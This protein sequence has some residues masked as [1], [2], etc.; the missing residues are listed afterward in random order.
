M[1][2]LALA[3]S[4]QAAGQVYDQAVTN[5]LIVVDA[6]NFR[7]NTAQ[8]G[9]TW[10]VVTVPTGFLGSGAMQ[11][12]PNNGAGPDVGYSSTSPRLDYRVLF[13]STGTHYVWLRARTLTAPAV[14]NND[15]CHTGLDGAEIPTADRMN[16]W[17]D[18]GYTWR[19][20]TMDAVNA[21]F[22]VGTLGVHTF[23]LWMREDGLIV[24]RIILTTNAGYNAAT[25]GDAAPLSAQIA[26]Q[27]PPQ[28]GAP[29]ITPGPL[30]MAVS[31]G[32]V[33]NADTYVLERSGGLPPGYRQI[34]SGPAQSFADS[35]LEQQVTYCYRVSGVDTAFGR[36]PA[37]PSTCAMALPPPPRTEG[38]D[39]G[40]LGDQCAC[41]SSIGAAPGALFAALVGL[42]LLGRRRP[43]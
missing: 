11:S 26:D 35:G 14:G 43:R 18:A 27:T 5:G 24:D 40:L 17:T 30:S 4:L 25:T 13:R 36:G 41:G 32:T 21:S 20:T 16:G 15:T 23:N 33:L 29:S 28:A 39:E 34:F 3:L 37:S 12:N 19:R 42:A 31:W 6:E 7:T 38:H 22:N 1:G 10:N 8:G 2:I 9:H